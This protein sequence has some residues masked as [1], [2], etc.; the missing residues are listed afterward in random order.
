[1]Q[2]RTEFRTSNGLTHAIDITGAQDGPIALLLHGFPD[3]KSIWANITP[4]LVN[5]GYQII[6]PDLR[7]FGETEMA[8]QKADYE[9]N[10]GAI[11]DILGLL[12][13]M[14]IKECHI[15]GHD[16]GAPVAWGLAARY[17][18]TFKSLTALSVGHNRAFLK[19]GTAQKLKSWYILFHQF[20]GLCEAIYHFNDWQALR[21]NWSGHG[22]LEQT[23]NLLKREGRLTAGLNWY[24]ANL[25]IARMLKPPA[26]G[27]FGEEIVSI[28][29]LGV[30]SDKDPY[31]TEEQM[32]LSKDYVEGPWTYEKI[33]NVGHWLQCDA[34]ETVAAL[35]LRHWESTE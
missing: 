7:G 10:A 29:T 11:P 9:I 13:E 23:I 17:P 22:N 18:E 14:N 12:R 5:A 33:E 35:L 3:S 27:T 31:L 34:P 1:M 16:F 19:A 25:S 24:R 2:T 4:T 20:P 30:W 28:P 6:A 26:F 8:K 15:V 32:T 21:Q